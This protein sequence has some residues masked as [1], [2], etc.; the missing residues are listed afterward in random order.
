MRTRPALVR[1]FVATL[2]VAGCDTRGPSRPATRDRGTAATDT[3]RGA[4]AGD[5]AEP[6][7]LW[8]AR[9]DALGADTQAP[10]LAACLAR[11]REG[12]GTSV[13]EA[14]SDL[15]YT[16]F[17]EDVCASERALATRDVAACA[18]ITATAMREGCA[19]RVATLTG[20]PERCPTGPSG[21]DALCLA[22]TTGELAYCATALAGD[23]VRCRAALE[24]DAEGCARAP[25]RAL[26]EATVAR[27]GGVVAPRVKRT[28]VAA[29]SS[30]AATREGGASSPLAGADPARGV[31]LVP[32][33]PCAHVITLEAP[34]ARFGTDDALLALEVAVPVDAALPFRVPIEAARVRVRVGGRTFDEELGASGAVIVERLTRAR[35]GAVTITLDTRLRDG[36]VRTRLSGRFESFVRD[37]EPACSARATP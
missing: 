3:R 13:A 29:R 15:G 28:V 16:R 37:L 9:I 2:L 18:S 26:C 20:D 25:D 30:L 21:R 36:D 8:P 5:A 6:S 10:E 19:L 33:A 14:L 11:H 32:R 31:R 35:L 22:F 12:L 24:D 7:S 27:F 4:D 34:L 1:L 17:F 23:R